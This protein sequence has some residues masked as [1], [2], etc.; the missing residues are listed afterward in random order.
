MRLPALALLF[1]TGASSSSTLGCVAPVM[2]GAQVA[3][4]TLYTYTGAHG[5]P[6]AYG[7]G[8]CPLDSRHGHRFGPVPRAAYAVADNGELTDLRTRYPF[9]NPHPHHDGTCFRETWHLHTEPARQGLTWDRGLAAFVARAD[10]APLVAVDGAHAALPCQ[11]A[12]CTFAGPHAHAPCA[13][14][15]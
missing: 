14:E 1:V 4:P 9:F 2:W 11:R 8:V 3:E 15:P 5:L 10:G 6:R 13:A 7:G 12:A